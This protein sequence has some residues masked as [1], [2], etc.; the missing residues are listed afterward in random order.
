MK[1]SGIGLS[2]VKKIIE[3]LDGSIQASTTNQ[4]F[5]LEITLP[6]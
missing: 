6:L 5:S 3:K 2:L 4:I 1:S